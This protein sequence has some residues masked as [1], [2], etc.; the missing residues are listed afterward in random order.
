MVQVVQAGTVSQGFWLLRS[1]PAC[2]S[3]ACSAGG[4]GGVGGQIYVCRGAG[5]VS[6][7][8]SSLEMKEF[9]HLKNKHS[10]IPAKHPSVLYNVPDR[11]RPSLGIVYI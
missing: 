5:G 11:I 10:S 1:L 2:A 7:H 3:P 6:Q 9:G 4:G 8:Q